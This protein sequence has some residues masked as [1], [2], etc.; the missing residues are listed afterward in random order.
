MFEPIRPI[1]YSASRWTLRTRELSLGRMPLLMGILNLT[2]DSFSDGGRFFTIQAAV[3]QARR[4]EDDGK[5][6]T[7]Q[8]EYFVG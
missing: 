1:P 2:P 3:D 6:A 4:I 7:V 5:H 8:P